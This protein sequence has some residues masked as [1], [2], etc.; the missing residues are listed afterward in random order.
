MSD[1][2]TIETT[3]ETVTNG[4]MN[5]IKGN[6]LELYGYGVDYLGIF[7]VTEE[8]NANVRILALVIRNEERKKIYNVNICIDTPIDIDLKK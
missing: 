3:L 8:E 5:L 1:D 7:D 4:I 2:N 6:D